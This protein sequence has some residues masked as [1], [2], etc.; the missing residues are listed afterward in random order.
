MTHMTEVRGK[1]QTI[2]TQRVKVRERRMHTHTHTLTPTH[3]KTNSH[4]ERWR[5]GV[6]EEGRE[7]GMAMRQCRR[8][9][10]RKGGTGG[11]KREC[12]K[13]RDGIRCGN[14]VSSF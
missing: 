8:K 10:Q 5:Q 3:I 2:C 11:E 1:G 9:R 12:G 14:R 13:E 6:R 7:G 4:T